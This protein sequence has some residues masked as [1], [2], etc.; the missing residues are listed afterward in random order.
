[1]LLFFKE[2]LW[3]KVVIVCNPKLK[4]GTKIDPIWDYVLVL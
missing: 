2:E 4:I 1:M 3:M